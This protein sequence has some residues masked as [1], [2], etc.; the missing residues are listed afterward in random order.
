MKPTPQ[1]YRLAT[2]TV[3]TEGKF[4]QWKQ[5]EVV[6]V[7]DRIGRGRYCIEKLVRKPNGI[8]P[9]L[10]LFNQMAGVPRSVLRFH[11]SATAPRKRRYEVVALYF[12]RVGGPHRVGRLG[13]SYKNA[14][15]KATHEF[16][17]RDCK[18]VMIYHGRREMY[19]RGFCND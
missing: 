19:A 1:K 10:P 13:H 9:G 6:K 18:A 4:T 14:L 8:H 7:L 11:K 17:Q 16:N 15:R 5:G 12:K 2:L 3:G